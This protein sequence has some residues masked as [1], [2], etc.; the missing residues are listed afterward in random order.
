MRERLV[1]SRK[2]LPEREQII[3]FGDATFE[4]SYELVMQTRGIWP[5]RI[6][7]YRITLGTFIDK[8]VNPDEYVKIAMEDSSALPGLDYLR[9]RNAMHLF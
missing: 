7:A 5:F 3:S 1:L 6:F 9:Y 2:R 8:T 4:A